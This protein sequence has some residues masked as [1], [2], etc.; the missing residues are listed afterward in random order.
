MYIIIIGT[1]RPLPF[2]KCSVVY[3]I[4]LESPESRLGPISI[5]ANSMHKIESREIS[6]RK[7]ISKQ[8]GTEY[9]KKNEE[10]KNNSGEPV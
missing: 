5:R 1:T 9:Q 6:N 4:I 2:S 3:V 8:Y 7:F 10:E